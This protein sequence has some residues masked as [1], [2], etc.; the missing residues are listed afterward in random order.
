MRI[1]VISKRALIIAVIV[2]AAIITA[3][4]LLLCFAPD[5]AAANT[6]AVEQYELEVLA[7]QKRSYPSTA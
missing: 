6:R 5:A 7:G 4:I 1:F 3:I 2:L